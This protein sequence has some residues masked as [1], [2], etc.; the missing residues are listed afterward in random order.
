M[1]YEKTGFIAPDRHA[2]TPSSFKGDTPERIDL[3][4]GR[5]PRGKVVLLAGAGGVGKSFLL[6]QAFEAINGGASHRTLGG[7]IV[8]KDLPCFGLLGEDDQGSIDLRLRAIREHNPSVK[9]VEHGYI[10]PVP[11]IGHMPLVKKGWDGTI[12]P[13]EV[14]EWLER[15]LTAALAEYGKL[16]FLVVDTFSTLL[17]VDANTPHEVQA[18]FSFLTSLAARLDI[19]IVV[20][21]HMNKGAGT[22]ADKTKTVEELRS[23]I[24]GSTA[25]EAA[26][27]A[28][29]VLHKL[30]SNDADRVRKEAQMDDYTGDVIQLRLVKDNLGLRTDPVTYIRMPNGRLLDV[31]G[32]LG[33]R[34]SDE[35]ALLQVV[36]DANDAGRKLTKTGT[37]GLFA[38]RAA[39][40]PGN[41]STMTRA[42]LEMLAN[43]LLQEGKLSSDAKGLTVPLCHR[44]PVPAVPVPAVPAHSRNFGNEKSV[45]IQ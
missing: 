18:A 33:R 7:Q 34:M 13:T 31:S 36:Q 2:F 42:P 27:R 32:L 1:D 23:G 15:V 44:L 35:D 3:V 19:C 28:A 8:G 38:S 21:H 24:R 20:T 26:V 10:W 5:F 39:S 4:A 43:Q 22:D 25:L 17:P 16:G 41:L 11:N 37:D 9:P 45:T 29:Y 30:G 14:L 40:W 12:K 6:L